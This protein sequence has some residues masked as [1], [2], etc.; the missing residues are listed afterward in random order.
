MKEKDR[1]RATA[2][3]YNGVYFITGTDSQGKQEKVFYVSYY[4]NGKRHFEK[5]GRQRQNG[6]TAYGASLL[7]TARI[8]GRELPN[9]ERRE[10]ERAAKDAEAG[11][12]TFDRLW[13]EWKAANPHKK[14]RVNDD[15]RYRTHLEG[16]FGDKEPRELVPLDV[17]RIRVRMLKGAAPPPGRR[18][19]PN[20]RRRVDYREATKRELAENAMENAAKREK[21]PYA[22]GTVKSVLSLLTRIA[23]FG[24]KRQLC[25][26]LRFKVE[27]PKGAKERTE[28]MTADQ[29]AA[30]IR[31]CREWPDAQAGNFQLLMLH[32]GMRRSE[33]R[34]LKWSDVDKERGFLLLRDPKGGE[35]VRIPLSDQ[36]AK[37][38]E[39]LP[40][41]V[42]NPFVFPGERGKGPRGARQIA[43][44]SRAIRDAA[45]L[46]ADF[47][48]NHG[49]R[50]TFASHLASSGETD[51]Y[52]LSKLLTHKSPTMTK[53]Y[54]HLTD[55]ALKRAANV[56]GRIVE[57][58]APE[59]KKAKGTGDGGEA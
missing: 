31:T 25:E 9:V 34:N 35:D 28:D 36:A 40:Q 54:A 21:K 20:A 7:R 26:G 16:P 5:A 19:D 41:V 48:P 23:N 33:V 51:L 37:I 58:A 24:V 32:T 17:E 2:T 18:F 4:R 56:M 55:T 57:Q 47:R 42:R 8:E 27:S 3:R 45:G 14:G 38:L 49:L 30:Y 29:M 50:H 52:T 10:A 43:D 53:R 39:E 1:F 44:S 11:R 22:V 59:L 6:M 46:P 12:W 15:N 13:R